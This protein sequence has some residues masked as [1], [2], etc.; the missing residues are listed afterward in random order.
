M[1]A[2]SSITAVRP[3]ESTT[4]SGPVLYGATISA[5]QTV[6]LD[7]SDNKYKLADAN[8]SAAAATIRG[9]AITPGVDGGYGYVAINGNIILVGTTMAVG[10]TYYVGQTAGS[11]VPDADLTTNDYVSRVGTASSTTQI[12]L[13]IS[14]TGIQHA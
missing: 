14:A 1:A 5:G 9:V 6:Y 8:L 13:S 2:L 7:S 10:E 3:T 4:V 11:I 12:A